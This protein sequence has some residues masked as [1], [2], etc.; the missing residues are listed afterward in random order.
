MDSFLSLC[1]RHRRTIL[2][3]LAVFLAL[4][5]SASSQG[6]YD[7]VD[8]HFTVAFWSRLAMVNVYSSPVVFCIRFI[9]HAVVALVL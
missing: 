6:F 9:K 1:S 8:K 2:L 7:E 3:A 5:T 4:H